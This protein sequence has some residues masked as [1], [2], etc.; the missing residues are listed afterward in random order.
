VRSRLRSPGATRWRQGVLPFR[1]RAE[2]LERAFQVGIAAATAAVVVAMI[3]G[4]PQGRDAAARL[5][6]RARWA[7]SRALGMHVDRAEIEAD[8]HRARLRGVDQARRALADREREGSPG[9]RE[10][11]RVAGMDSRSAVIR[12]GNHD[13]TLALSSHVFEPDDAGR[14]Y[15][16][17][18]K[19]RSTWLVGLNLFGVAAMFEIPD[20]PEARR[21]GQAVGGRPVPGSDQSTNSWGCRGA[22]PDPSAPVRGIVLGDSNMQGLLVGDD[23]APPARL[24]A[25]LRRDLGVPVSVL[26]AGVLGYSLEQYYHTLLAFHDRLRPQF[27][28][29]SVCDNDLGDLRDPARWAEAETWLEAITQ[30]CRTRRILCLIVPVPAEFDMLGTRDES[31]FPGRLSLISRTSAL[32]YLNPLEEFATEEIRL[33]VEARRKGEPVPSSRL[34]NGKYGDKHFSPLG[35]DLWAAIV[36]RRLELLWGDVNPRGIG[37]L[38][39][40]PK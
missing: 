19:A 25:R 6:T 11:L 10:F 36:A 27:V 32:F 31:L 23:E 1:R 29:V 21:L 2:R 22:E 24:E 38:R 20:T 40:G 39:P 9:F 7:T 12:W 3:A 26:N 35:S 15:R 13:W 18:P 17:R 37:P 8:R 14:S 5:A 34:F 4:S 28:V 33:R 30:V 16:L